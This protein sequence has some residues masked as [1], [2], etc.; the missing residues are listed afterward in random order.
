MSSTARDGTLRNW[1]LI[2]FGRLLHETFHTS[3]RPDKVPIYALDLWAKSF[4]IYRYDLPHVARCKPYDLHHL[5]HTSCIESVQY[6]PCTLCHQG[7]LGSTWSTC[8]RS[9]SVRCVKHFSA[10]ERRKT[11][12]QVRATIGV[13]YL[14]FANHCISALRG[15]LCNHCKEL[16]NINQCI[17][18]MST[19]VCAFISPQARYKR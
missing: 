8:S 15:R 4:M 5:A 16:P 18:E 9:W 2:F 7:R 11:R 12:L 19:M 10:G 3:D 6:R 1:E 13:L 17:V 14:F